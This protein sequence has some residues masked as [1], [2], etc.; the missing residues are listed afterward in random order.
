MCFNLVIASANIEFCFLKTEQ[1]ICSFRSLWFNYIW[2]LSVA[3]VH[4][5]SV[6]EAPNKRPIRISASLNDRM[7]PK[8]TSCSARNRTKHTKSNR[9][10]FE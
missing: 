4:Q 8:R 2:S 3:E 5:P 7:E 6:A 1:I 9:I 10:N